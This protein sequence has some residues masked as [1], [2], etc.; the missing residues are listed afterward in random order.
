MGYSKH[1][2]STKKTCTPPKICHITPQPP[3]NGHFLLSPLRG[4]CGVGLTVIWVT[5]LQV[6]SPK[7]LKIMVKQ[8]IPLKRETV[9][10]M[11]WR[12]H[13]RTE[14]PTFDLLFTY[15]TWKFSKIY[16]EIKQANSNWMFSSLYSFIT[17]TKPYD[18]LKIKFY[19]SSDFS[20][21]FLCFFSLIFLSLNT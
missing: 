16:G 1:E 2:L 9:L 4:R 8:Y 10:S 11:N 15:K 12:S 18:K 3:H 14:L 13:A 19:D 5:H 17:F 20:L 6:T 21:T 7:W